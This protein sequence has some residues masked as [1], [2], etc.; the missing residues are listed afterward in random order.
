MVPAGEQCST[1]SVPT[2]TQ[3]LSTGNLLISTALPQ[4]PGSMVLPARR[5]PCL[6]TLKSCLIAQ[7]F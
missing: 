2:G 5:P 6:Y 7:D 3:V 4:K 1:I